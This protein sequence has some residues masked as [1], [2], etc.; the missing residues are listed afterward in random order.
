MILIGYII[1]LLCHYPASFYVLKKL[2]V[3]ER[4]HKRAL[5]FGITIAFTQ[6]F[7]AILLLSTFGQSGALIGS[8]IGLILSYQYVKKVLVV[9]WQINVAIII[10][11]PLTT[12]FALAI[13][14]YMFMPQQ[15]VG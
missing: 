3:K 15:A 9:K 1:F 6:N 13:L 2:G 5:T 10:F 4:I 11:V 8:V 7:F 12:S 14:M